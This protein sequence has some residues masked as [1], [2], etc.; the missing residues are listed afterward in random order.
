MSL[1]FKRLRFVRLLYHSIFIDIEN[2]INDGET[3]Y[4]HIENRA[5]QNVEWIDPV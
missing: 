1:I 5:V 4:A 2:R 3:W